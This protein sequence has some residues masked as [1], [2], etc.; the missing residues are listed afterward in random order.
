MNKEEVNK[1]IDVYDEVIADLMQDKQQLKERIA[2]LERSNNRRE[3]T[4]IQYR[5]SETPILDELK[6][7]L[8]E[9]INE[10]KTND[11]YDRTEYQCTQIATLESVKAKIE[12]L[13]G[14]E[15]E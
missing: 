15:N 10:I 13:R 6:K 4:I 1:I 14:R 3:D 11:I 8:D 5:M 12:E 9:C 7:W 2:Y